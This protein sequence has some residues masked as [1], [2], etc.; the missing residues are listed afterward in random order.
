MDGN[1]GQKEAYRNKVHKNELSCYAMNELRQQLHHLVDTLP[2]QSLEHAKSALRYC[3]NPE[4]H[5]MTIENAKRRALENSNRHL[6]AYAERMGRGFVTG[7]GS[8]GDTTNLDGSY[9]S[10]MMAF[11]NGKDATFHLYIYRGT[12]FEVIETM[13]I[14]DDGQ[15][16]IRRERI[17]ASDGAEQILSAELPIVSR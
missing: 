12:P 2:E 14:S 4:Q 7:I 5:R 13:E 1:Q 16:L 8:G 11:E 10:S 15:R 6:R 3:V 17:T 9:H